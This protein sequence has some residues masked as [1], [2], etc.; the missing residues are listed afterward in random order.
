[1]LS[2]KAK[3]EVFNQKLIYSRL[4]T[5]QYRGLKDIEDTSFSVQGVYEMVWKTKNKRRE[6][7]LYTT[8]GKKQQ[9]M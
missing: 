7:W 9:E 1:M 2:F 4:S 8:K 3:Q 5:T 6:S